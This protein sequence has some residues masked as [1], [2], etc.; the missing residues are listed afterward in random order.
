E[1]V[2]S[3]TW[4]IFLKLRIRSAS[5]RGGRSRWL[6]ECA[7][8]EA[9]ADQCG[10]ERL[11]RQRRTRAPHIARDLV[12]HHDTGRVEDA[13]SDELLE[14]L[15]DERGGDEVTDDADRTQP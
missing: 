7:E 6:C 14:S 3:T 5:P 9:P 8:H 1:A 13:G 15:N 10:L 2:L 4:R 12:D 11:D